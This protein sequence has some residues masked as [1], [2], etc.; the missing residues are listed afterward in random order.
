MFIEV[1]P[2]LKQ[3]LDPLLRDGQQP[4]VVD[5]HPPPQ[6]GEQIGQPGEQNTQQ[7]TRL[8]IA[9]GLL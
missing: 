2:Q 4:R 7:P 1:A 5:T 3:H 8:C 9:F 6:L